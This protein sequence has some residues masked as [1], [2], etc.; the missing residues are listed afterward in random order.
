MIVLDV[1]QAS[2]VDIHK[3]AGRKSEYTLCCPFCID[4]GESQDYRYRL[5]INAGTG[6]GQ[7]F[8]CGW[9]SRSITNT[10]HELCKA[11]GLT[12]S[13]KLKQEL[14]NP[15]EEVEKELPSETTLPE[16][17]EAFASTHGNDPIETKALKY[18][19]VDRKI[20]DKQ[21]KSHKIGFCA[22]GPY[23]WRIVF[24]IIDVDAKIYGFCTRDFSGKQTPKYLN[25]P[26]IKLLWGA[27]KVSDTAVVVEGVIDALRVESALYTDNMVA[28]AKLG[29]AVT[30][31]QLDQL[32]RY[33]KVIILPDWDKPG[34]KGAMAFADECANA[35]LNVSVCIPSKMDDSDPGSMSIPDILK[36]IDSHVPWNKGSEFRM[37]VAMNK[38]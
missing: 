37:K 33:K 21:I 25:S 11:F 7:C 15:S 31:A 8:N 30:D 5:G 6:F 29:S 19:L 20:S 38:V 26:G 23:S 35:K 12:Y 14:A 24:P 22:S 4:R 28:L 10:V 16:E 32:K 17:Y 9:K 36:C 1:L 34:V 18:L 27:H 3:V 13:V 2:A